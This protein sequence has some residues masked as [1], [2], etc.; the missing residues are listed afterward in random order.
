MLWASKIMF[1]A[2]T[3]QSSDD[4]CRR[5]AL[6]PRYVAP[7]AS[8]A[9]RDTSGT[10]STHPPSRTTPTTVA[11]SIRLRRMGFTAVRLFR[12]SGLSASPGGADR[13]SRTCAARC[14]ITESH[15]GI[16]SR[17]NRNHD[18]Y[19]DECDDS[20]DPTHDVP[21]AA[22]DSLIHLCGAQKLDDD[23]VAGRA[24]LGGN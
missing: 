21:E 10:R 12:I 13:P 3:P 24:V 15:H 2:A 6:S 22:A 23:R 5:T 17:D 1:S 14:L 11:T 7:N 9:A 18:V 16:S 19:H 8:A 4:R 20:D